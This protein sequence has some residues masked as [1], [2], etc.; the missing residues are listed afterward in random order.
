MRLSEVRHNISLPPDQ[1][2]VLGRFYVNFNMI[3][4]DVTGTVR[5]R[6]DHLARRLPLETLDLGVPTWFA[7]WPHRRS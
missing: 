5:Y 4:V 1:L 3:E 7:G 2:G 6:I